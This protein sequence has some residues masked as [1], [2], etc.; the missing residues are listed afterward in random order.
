MLVPSGVS[1]GSNTVYF[2][3]RQGDLGKTWYTAG[4]GSHLFGD[5]LS[6]YSGNCPVSNAGY[7]DMLSG[8][9]SVK[10]GDVTMGLTV[11]SPL[12]T[13]SKLPEGVTEARWVWLF[14][15]TTEHLT[16]DYLV[17]I[18]W[19]GTDF[20]AT[21]VDKTN[22]P[23]PFAVTS[24]NS[25][26]VDG[27]VLTVT[28]SLASIPGVVAWYSQTEIM[29]GSPW[30]LDQLASS[31]AWQAPDITDFGTLMTYWPWQAMP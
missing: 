13:D 11:D 2:T 25:F 5:P 19:D 7:L 21:L 14:F 20:S 9:V 27:Q 12:T 18:L 4:Q 22:G 8:W 10:S 31:G 16:P 28:M 30:P 3:D 17:Y 23:P 1:A 26:I 29:H 15:E 6:W 24:L